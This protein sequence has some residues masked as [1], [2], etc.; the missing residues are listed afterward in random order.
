MNYFFNDDQVHSCNRQAWK[1]IRRSSKFFLF[2]P[3]GD[4]SLRQDKMRYWYSSIASMLAC[5]H[6]ILLRSVGLSWIQLVTVR[7]F[8]ASFGFKIAELES[9]SDRFF[10]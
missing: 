5:T 2:S 9:L 8:L 3:A 1:M 10:L 7:R 4:V 6:S